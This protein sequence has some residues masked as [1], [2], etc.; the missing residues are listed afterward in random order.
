V[1]TKVR[2]W[3]ASRAAASAEIE[4]V[5]ERVLV[6]PPRGH[7]RRILMEALKAKTRHV[8]DFPKPGIL[9]YDITTLLNDAQRFREHR[10][11]RQTRRFRPAV[12][13]W[14]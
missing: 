1:S 13:N 6:E 3:A 12:L 4:S 10:S 5:V 7:R 9:F 8:P 14:N 2:C 11:D